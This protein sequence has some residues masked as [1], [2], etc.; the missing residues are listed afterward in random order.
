MCVVMRPADI[1]LAYKQ[2]LYRLGNK[3]YIDKFYEGLTED[4]NPVLFFFRPKK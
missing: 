2:E 1:V 3:E 4:S